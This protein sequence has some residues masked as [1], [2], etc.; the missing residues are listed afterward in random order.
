MPLKQ[1]LL[2]RRLSGEER[3]WVDANATVVNLLPRVQL[4]EH[5]QRLRHVYFPLSASVAVMRDLMDGSSAQVGIIGN[6]GVVAYGALI[7]GRVVNSR[8]IVQVPG[9]FARFDVGAM[10][11]WVLERPQFRALLMHYGHALLSH[12]MQNVICTNFHQVRQRLALLLLQT[13]DRVPDHVL[14]LT[15]DIIADM[16]GVRRATVSEIESRLQT[17]GII[18][19]QR[20]KIEILDRDA[21]AALACECYGVIRAE[22]DRFMQDAPYPRALSAPRLAETG[23]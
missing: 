5:R 6:E 1:N 13:I 14:P 17:Q 22:Y 8:A 3:S 12:T 15:Q 23:A 16:L 11:D 4:Y 7:D 18:R 2:L 20:G 19:Y 9:A 10:Q 21:L